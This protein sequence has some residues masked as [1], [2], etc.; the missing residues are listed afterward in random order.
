MQTNRTLL[1]VG[2][3]EILLAVLL[4][5]HQYPFAIP[6]GATILF[7]SLALISGIGCGMRYARGEWGMARI[8]RFGVLWPIITAILV[9]ASLAAVVHYSNIQ[10]AIALAAIV[11]EIVFVTGVLSRTRGTATVS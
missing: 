2:I 4:I 6:M 9:G 3:G 7:L 1:A 8:V 11:S 10:P 5:G